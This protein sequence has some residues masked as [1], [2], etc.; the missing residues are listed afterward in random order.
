MSSAIPQL[1]NWVRGQWEARNHGPGKNV[2][3]RPPSGN[4]ENLPHTSAPKQKKERKRRKASS[5]T[6]LDEQKPKKRR[7]CRGNVIP[8]TM[9]SVLKLQDE[10]EEG[11]QEE[12]NEDDSRLIAHA[13]AR[14]GARKASKLVEVDTAQPRPDEVEEETSDQ[15]PEP[16]G[17]E[18][19]LP[20]GKKAIEEAMDAGT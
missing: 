13:R 17:T 6:K 10:T 5:S 14:T 1:E 20:R 4:E 18:D 9:D 2:P 7:T 16:K 15:V 12:E 19:V 8:L 3:M 11:E